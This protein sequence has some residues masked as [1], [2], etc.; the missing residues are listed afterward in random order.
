MSSLFAVVEVGMKRL[1]LISEV[2]PVKIII[3]QFLVL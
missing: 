3:A 2:L 1:L